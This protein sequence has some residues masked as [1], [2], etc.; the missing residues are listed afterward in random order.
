M[1]Q[2]FCELKTN[3]N[4][5][6][7]KLN[8]CRNDISTTYCRASTLEKPLLHTRNVVDLP[9]PKDETKNR[10]VITPLLSRRLALTS[11]TVLPVLLV[12]VKA[13]QPD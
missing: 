10:F 2:H 12:A 6:V 8:P 5:D 3:D 7:Q 4:P 9:L 1:R 11:L 13:T